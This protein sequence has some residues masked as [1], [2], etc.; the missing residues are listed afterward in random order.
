VIREILI[1]VMEFIGTVAFAVS[2]ALVAVGCSLDLFGVIIV[3]CVTAVGGGM[4]RDLLLGRTPPQIFYNPVILTV[5][6]TTTLIVFVASYIR[7]SRFTVIRERVE[8]INNLFDALGLAAFSVT[9]VG[10]ALNGGHDG[11]LIAITMGVL[12]GVGGGVLRDVLV[13][14]KPYIFTKHIYAVASIIGSSIYY[15][16]ATYTDHEL[17]G[18]FAA[19]VATITI[20]LLAAKYRWALPKIKF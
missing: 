20:R 15:V 17:A 14:E 13:N 19:V 18:T 8:R 3:G 1:T 4:I 9:G 16:C 5:A 12:T 10:V 2:G 6:V 11:A 7:H